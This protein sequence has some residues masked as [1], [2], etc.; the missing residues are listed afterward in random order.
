M[1]KEDFEIFRAP[2]HYP[3][4]L[5][6]QHVV[7]VSPHSKEK[8]IADA[9]RK[10]NAKYLAA[11]R[12]R[13][14]RAMTPLATAEWGQKTRL[15]DS[16]KAK[17]LFYLGSED[18]NSD[19]CLGLCNE[20]HVMVVGGTRGGKGTSVIIPNL[21][22]WEGSAV[23]IDPK[24]ENA[25]VTA[26][27]RGTGSVFCQGMGQNVYILDPFHV[28]GRDDD[29]MVD[30]QAQFNPLRG[31]SKEDPRVIDLVNEIASSMIVVPK[32][33]DSQYWMQA[34]RSLLKA[35]I[36]HVISSHE[37][38]E[39]KQNLVT[40]YELLCHGD[41]EKK[42]FLTEIG[43]D[44]VPA[45]HGLL[46]KAME[47]NT[48][49]GGL[50]A[51][52]GE[53]YSKLISTAEKQYHGVIE[54]LKS[55]LEFMDSPGV[56]ECLLGSSFTL[57]DLKNDPNGTTV[58]LCLPLSQLENQFR[59]LRIIIMQAL[60]T[61]E[62]QRYRPVSG[63]PVL[64]VLDEFAALKRMPIMQNAIAQMAGHGV[65][66]L[67]AI[68][69][70]NQI[71]SEYD[72]AWETFMANCG[73]KLFLGNDD[74]FTRNYVSRLV[75][76]TVVEVRNRS[77]ADGTSS[78]TASGR[79]WSDASSKSEGHGKTATF[80]EG[81]GSTNGPGLTAFSTNKNWSRSV[82]YTDQYGSSR[83]ETFGGSSTRTTGQSHTY[84][85]QVNIQT[86][87][88]VRPDEIGRFFAHKADPDGLP[89]AGETLVLISGEQPIAVKRTLY[90]RH[91]KFEGMFDAHRDFPVEAAYRSPPKP[92]SPLPLPPDYAALPAPDEVCLV[93]RRKPT[94][95]PWDNFFR[96]ICDLGLFL[97]WVFINWYA[98]CAFWLP[99]AIIAL[100]FVFFWAIGM[101]AEFIILII[102]G[103]A[104]VFPFILGGWV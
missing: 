91:L 23:V 15:W 53:T 102:A 56:Q 72:R 31:L 38:P 26:R 83:T 64:M 54:T 73:V 45:S 101:A 68:Q 35:V 47:E 93:P 22:I 17:G 9:K 28:A 16:Q 77:L 65:K 52:A 1:T 75:G 62:R 60:N 18:P 48:A 69:D 49:F 76:E 25:T 20:Q 12:E 19:D 5:K 29:P 46:F 84:T 81:G 40:V 3:S 61:F 104:S 41:R 33:G 14:L 95:T 42:E 96:F 80:A 82:S 63:W 2:D 70:L 27:R 37:Y 66:F 44:E 59:W 55:N 71:A 87:P 57:D 78:S 94:P 103:V 32:E 97:S 8:T 43:A 6:D 90:F 98:F 7:G 13:E 30:L 74:D 39:G 36:L 4:W 58:Y 85:M 21:L 89:Y 50:I 34:A 79:S 92:T 67:I 88:L 86:R 24:G 99:L 11:R 10:N 51:S 100:I